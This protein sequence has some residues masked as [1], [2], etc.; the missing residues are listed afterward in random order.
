MIAC[1]NTMEPTGGRPLPPTQPAARALKVRRIRWFGAG[2][3]ARSG[4]SAPAL[5]LEV[6]FA[7]EAF[8]PTIRSNPNK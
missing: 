3:T 8:T 4:R 2:R 1:A 6:Q 7:E 5:S